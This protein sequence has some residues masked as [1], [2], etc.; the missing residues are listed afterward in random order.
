MPHYI[1]FM[2]LGCMHKGIIFP[3]I[4]KTQELQQ[5]SFLNIS[6]FNYT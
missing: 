6:Q 1:Y 5:Y 4:V 3:H 2:S